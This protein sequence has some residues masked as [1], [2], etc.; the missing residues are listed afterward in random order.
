MNKTPEI[1]V[2]MPVYNTEL[3]LDKAIKSILEQ[4]FKNFEF[5]IINDGST[6][7]S[8]EIIQRYKKIDNRIILINRENKGLIHSLNEGIENSKGEYIA[9]MDADDISFPNRFEEQIKLIKKDNA[10]ICGSHF[11]IINEEDEFIDTFIVPLKKRN[12]LNYLCITTPFAHPS[13][14]LK[15][16]FLTQ[17]NIQ[18]GQTIYQNAEDYALWVQ[19]WNL[20][21]KFTNVNAFLFKYRDVKQSLSSEKQKQIVRE[22]RKISKE[23]VLNNHKKLLLNY[24]SMDFTTLS[25]MEQRLIAVSLM[26][27]IKY[28]LSL[29]C[30]KILLKINKSSILLGIIQFFRVWY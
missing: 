7:A 10:D 23:M 11:F 29:K 25:K 15:K 16:S 27:L 3:F 22:K 17:N 1:S 9:R 18:Y 6:D 24:E 28:R 14:M 2:I 4:S 12:F 13:V 19:F 20:G 5:I 21:A 26:I 30:I 8:L